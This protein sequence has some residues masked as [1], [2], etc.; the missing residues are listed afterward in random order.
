MTEQSSLDLQKSLDLNIVSYFINT[1]A[2]P[3][4]NTWHRRG[5]PITQTIDNFCINPNYRRSVE[6]TWKT[7]IRSTDQGV[8]YKG[9]HGTGKDGRPYLL[10]S[11]YE[12]NLLENSFQNHLVLRYAMLLINC[13]RQ[14]HGENGVSSSTFNLAFRRLQPKITKNSK[15]TTSYKELGKVEICK[16]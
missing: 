13:H 11:S 9:R 3:H 14:K 2:S 16:V 1:L 10:S 8:K 6:H 5:R 12:I 15:N 4:A 7:F